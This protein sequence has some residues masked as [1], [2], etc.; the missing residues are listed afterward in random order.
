MKQ[1]LPGVREIFATSAYPGERGSSP[2]RARTSHRPYS[3][4]ASLGEKRSI[5]GAMACPRPGALQKSHAH[6]FLPS[7]LHSHI[8]RWQEVLLTTQV[9]A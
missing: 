1:F 8:L 2:S 9:W 3:G 6:P 4:R 7:C 5:V